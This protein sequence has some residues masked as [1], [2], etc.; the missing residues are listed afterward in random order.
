MKTQSK[1]GI[2]GILALFS[3][4]VYAWY[5]G[6]YTSPSA[7]TQ[8]SFMISEKN[9]RGELILVGMGALV[10]LLRKDLEIN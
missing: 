7:F 3:I 2:I 8:Y 5:T 10:F 6:N 9:L 4:I 1:I